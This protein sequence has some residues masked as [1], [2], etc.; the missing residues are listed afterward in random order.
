MK[1]ELD[2]ESPIG[3]WLLEFCTVDAG[4]KIWLILYGIS[5][6]ET[7]SAWSK[8]KQVNG[9]KSDPT[10]IKNHILEKI[11]G[12]KNEGDLSMQL[13]LTADYEGW[14]YWGSGIPEPLLEYYQSGD[15]HKAVGWTPKW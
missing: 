3:P 12:T 5:G 9:R 11:L 1:I 10:V 4:D 8:E 6:Q 13:M 2:R 14:K 7:F 15:F